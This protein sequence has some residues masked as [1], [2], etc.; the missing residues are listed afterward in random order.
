MNVLMTI[1]SVIAGIVV[2]AAGS[3]YV[4]GVID[5][6]RKDEEPFNPESRF[7]Y[8]LFSLAFQIWINL[9][10]N[11]IYAVVEAVYRSDGVMVFIY[12]L[13]RGKKVQIAEDALVFE[14]ELDKEFGDEET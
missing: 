3:A 7:A 5:R 8:G 12:S 6:L 14:K 4:S 9:S 2:F 11:A 1:L 10:M 13:G